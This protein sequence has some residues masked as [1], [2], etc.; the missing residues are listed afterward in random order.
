MNRDG[1]R[2]GTGHRA[3]TCWISPNF[4]VNTP[5]SFSPSILPTLILLA[6]SM[7]HQKSKRYLTL[8]PAEGVKGICARARYI[9]R[10]IHTSSR[11]A[12]NKSQLTAAS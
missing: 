9:Q 4:L 7:I 11:G 6:N 12:L 3:M 1:P 2:E 10:P 8:S 5:R